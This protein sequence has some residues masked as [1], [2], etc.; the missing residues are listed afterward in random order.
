MHYNNNNNNK[1]YYYY[2]VT[3][4]LSGTLMEIW[5]LKDMYRDTNTDTHTV[6]QYYQSRNLLQYVAEISIVCRQSQN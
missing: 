3:M 1:Y 5:R 2:I 6:T 4:R